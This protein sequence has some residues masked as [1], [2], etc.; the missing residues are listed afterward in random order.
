LCLDSGSGLAVGGEDYS[1]KTEAMYRKPKDLNKFAPPQK[2][3]DIL[4]KIVDA[5]R[6]AD[7]DKLV[8]V[9]LKVRVYTG[10]S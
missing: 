10:K 9:A 4:Q 1:V 8:H 3:A 2:V 7:D 5:L 6:T